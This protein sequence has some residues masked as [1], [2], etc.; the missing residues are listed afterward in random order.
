M[1]M[2]NKEA[3]YKETEKPEKE[4]QTGIRQPLMNACCTGVGS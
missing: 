4:A 1:W 3:S 2:N